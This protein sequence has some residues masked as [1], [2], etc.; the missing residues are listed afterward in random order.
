MPTSPSNSS[1]KNTYVIDVENAAELARLIHQDRLTTKSMG[2][3]LAEQ[4]DL[5]SY[6]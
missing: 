1:G 3:L 2:G 5:S 4:P 6:R